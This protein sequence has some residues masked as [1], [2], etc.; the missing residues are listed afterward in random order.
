MWLRY[1]SLPARILYECACSTETDLNGKFWS[2]C[3]RPLSEAVLTLWHDYNNIA[4]WPF[5]CSKT[6]DIFVVLP[7]NALR[8]NLWLW[9]MRKI[10]VSFD[11]FYNI[12]IINYF[13]SDKKNVSIRPTLI[14]T[15]VHY[16]LS[17]HFEFLD[18][19]VFRVKQT[20]LTNFFYVIKTPRLFWFLVLYISVHLTK[21]KLAFAFEAVEYGTSLHSNIVVRSVLELENETESYYVSIFENTG[22]GFNFR[23]LCL[24]AQQLWIY[25]FVND[26]NRHSLKHSLTTCFDHTK[27]WTCLRPPYLLMFNDSLPK[28]SVSATKSEMWPTSFLVELARER[29]LRQALCASAAREYFQSN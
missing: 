18:R 12:E 19:P 26:P 9:F 25:S 1:N 24:A 7:S 15:L 4:Y 27:Y 21:S 17:L 8:P 16:Y 3:E 2:R 5:W 22:R 20:L 23:W 6:G 14:E 11:V 10:F 13:C 29:R 28:Y